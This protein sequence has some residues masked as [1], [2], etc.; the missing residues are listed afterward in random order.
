MDGL[1]IILSYVGSALDQLDAN[2]RNMTAEGLDAVM[3]AGRKL[4]SEY[5]EHRAHDFD[6]EQRRCFAKLLANAPLGGSTTRSVI[7]DSLKQGFGPDEAEKLFRPC[8]AP[9]YLAQAK[10]ALCSTHS[11]YAR[12]A[13]IKLR[14]DRNSSWFGGEPRRNVQKY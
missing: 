12:L 2:N 3:G 5:Y 9:W 7:M 8:T 13:G 1:S 4:R 11:V 6:E 10:R 14:Q